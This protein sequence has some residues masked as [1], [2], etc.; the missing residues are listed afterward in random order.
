ML[1]TREFHNSKLLLLTHGCCGMPMIFQKAFLFFIIVLQMGKRCQNPRTI[2]S[3]QNTLLLEPYKN[4]DANDELVFAFLQRRPRRL[5]IEHFAHLSSR[6][7][8]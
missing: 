4:Y 8:M 5:N 1:P 7:K 2:N 3:Q 6:D